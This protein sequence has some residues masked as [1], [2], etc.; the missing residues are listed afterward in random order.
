MAFENILIRMKNATPHNAERKQ[1]F[2]SR[3][4]QGL[5]LNVH[6]VKISIFVIDS[7]SPSLGKL[8]TKAGEEMIINTKRYIG[9]QTEKYVITKT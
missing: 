9:S 3:K 6:S 8:E 5:F 1:A 2:L 4:K 7:F